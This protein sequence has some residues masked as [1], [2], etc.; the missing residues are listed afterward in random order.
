MC[1]VLTF[2][3]L[4]HAQVESMTKYLPSQGKIQQNGNERKEN[5]FAVNF[6]Q[7]NFHLNHL[8]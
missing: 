1:Y 3:V 6:G 2:H 5:R 7:D 8:F 4:I